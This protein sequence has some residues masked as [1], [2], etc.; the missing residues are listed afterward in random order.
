M[1][2][3]PHTMF[4][5]YMEQESKLDALNFPEDLKEILLAKGAEVI[6]VNDERGEGATLVKFKHSQKLPAEL[7]DG[8]CFIGGTARTVVLRELEG[9]AKSARDIDIVAIKEFEPDPSIREQLSTRYMSQDVRHGY[10]IKTESILDYIYHRDFTMNEIL[11]HGDEVYASPQALLDL[12]NKTVRP[13]IYQRELWYDYE[14]ETN[15][16]D[17]KLV[18]KA[19]RIQVEF[20]E[21]YGEGNVE[22]LEKWQFTTDA[23]PTFFIALQLERAFERGDNVAFGFFTKL[24]EHGTVSKSRSPKVSSIVADTPEELALALNW[25]LKEDERNPFIF[26]DPR[27][28]TGESPAEF[29]RKNPNCSD[30]ELYEHYAEEADSGRKRIK[31][32][33]GKNKYI[34]N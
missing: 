8:Y 29:L 9:G 31:R 3:E 32:R 22:G 7:P 19:L 10:G 15:R 18:M 5:E 11:V 2:A 4:H 21:F 20:E 6:Y 27:F 33:G 16:I 30:E 12:H 25:H 26:T 34:D 13:S 23:G 24:I 1:A 17:P 14:T 28:N